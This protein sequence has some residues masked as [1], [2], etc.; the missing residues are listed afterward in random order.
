MRIHNH[1][2][3]CNTQS[4]AILGS[5]KYFDFV[6][7]SIVYYVIRY[8]PNSFFKI[9]PPIF[10]FRPF[11]VVGIFVRLATRC[12]N[13]DT[14]TALCHEKESPGIGVDRLLLISTLSI[15][16]LAY[17]SIALLSLHLLYAT[18]YHTLY[19]PQKKDSFGHNN[20]LNY[21]N[22]FLWHDCLVPS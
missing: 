9:P 21:S 1:I 6:H 17:C 10:C 5:T 18:Q 11:L 20:F 16:L 4:R 13:R 14:P 8:R 3:M 12:L 15:E 19:Q 7:L 22:T 2:G